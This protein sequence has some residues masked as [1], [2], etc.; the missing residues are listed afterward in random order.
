MDH[1]LGMKK[2]EC[3]IMNVNV[4]SWSRLELYAVISD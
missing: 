2:E 1:C 4:T 3:E